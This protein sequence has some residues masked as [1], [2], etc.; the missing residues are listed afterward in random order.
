VPQEYAQDGF[1]NISYI[2]P[3]TRTVLDTA[4]MLDAMAGPDSRDPLTTA[5]GKPDFVAAAKSE[6]I[7]A[8]LRIGWR[9]RLGNTAVA[10]EVLAACE[11]VLQALAGLGATIEELTAPFE[12]PERVWFVVNGAYRMA[13][14]GHHLKQQRDIMCPT[15][16]RQLDRIASASSAELY[17]AIFE[18]TRLYRQV[19]AWFD[20][21]DI[22]AMPTLSRAAVPI[23]Q[24]FF[25]PIEIDGELIDNIR[26]AWYPYT[27]PFNLTGNP[28]VS[29]PAGFD[30]AGMP[31][32]IQL[33]APPG[34]DAA[35]L[36]I[37]AAFERACPWA[38]RQPPSKQ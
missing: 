26:A 11:T 5:R 37:A 6:E 30:G 28:A 33:V 25:G 38:H 13:Q 22:V 29:L 1:G 31:L 8:G 10:R 36:R 12:N 2:T 34:A 27:M 32:A 4:L 17:D 7:P 19:Q 15:F 24:D 21:C 14:F 20:V 3:M 9:P 16:V 23:D 18:R 35:L